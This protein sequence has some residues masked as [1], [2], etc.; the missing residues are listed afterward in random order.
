MLRHGSGTCAETEAVP[1]VEGPVGS[2]LVR[3]ALRSTLPAGVQALGSGSLT[4]GPGTFPGRQ[5]RR[6]PV[7]PEGEAGAPWT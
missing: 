1:E 4:A 7:L 2:T 5:T 6:S 3:G